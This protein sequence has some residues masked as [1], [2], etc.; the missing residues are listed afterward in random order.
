MILDEQIFIPS[1]NA[2]KFQVCS[3][4]SV[5]LDA[6]FLFGHVLNI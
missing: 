1:A 5:V 4:T 2:V 3:L 6:T